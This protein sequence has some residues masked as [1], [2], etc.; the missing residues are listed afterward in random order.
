MR[1]PAVLRSLPVQ[2]AVATKSPWVYTVQGVNPDAILHPPGR[3]SSL[4]GEFTSPESLNFELPRNGRPELAFAGRSNAG[5]STLIGKIIGTSKLVRTSKQPGCTKTINFFALRGDGAG[6]P[7]SYLV[8]LPG[9]GF[10]REKREAVREWAAVVRGYLKE[11][12]CNVLRRAFVLVDSRHGLQRGDRHI[13][14]TL[15]ESGVSTQIILTKVD[16]VQPAVLLKAVE[17]VCQS[18]LLHQSCFPVV[19]C[20]SARTGLGMAELTNTVWH[21]CSE[22]LQKTR[23]YPQRQRQ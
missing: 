18:L 7:Q 23:Q 8:D 2:L 5:K 20:V 19:H 1:A 15:D 3:L 21:L 14:S 6:P 17:G 22:P 16:K 12:P 10:A 9:Y 4:R 13:L 11:R